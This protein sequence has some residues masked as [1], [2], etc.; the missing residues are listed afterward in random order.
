[1]FNLQTSI[2]AAVSYLGTLKTGGLGFTY[3]KLKMIK[4]ARNWIDY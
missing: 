3:C 2:F 4:I 1:M